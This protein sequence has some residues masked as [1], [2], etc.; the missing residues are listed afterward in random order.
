M[1]TRPQERCGEQKQHICRFCGQPIRPG[2]VP[3]MILLEPDYELEEFRPH[4]A[5]LQC[6]HKGMMTMMPSWGGSE[7]GWVGWS[8]GYVANERAWSTSRSARR[9]STM[10]GRWLGD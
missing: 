10:A 6:G 4:S 5:C 2:V 3:L 9:T 7:H 8:K 1:T